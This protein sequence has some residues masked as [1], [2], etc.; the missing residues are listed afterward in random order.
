MVFPV[1]SS[2][3]GYLRVYVFSAALEVWREDGEIKEG[4]SRGQEGPS[5]DGGRD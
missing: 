1:H 5:P 2:R 3:F 4:G